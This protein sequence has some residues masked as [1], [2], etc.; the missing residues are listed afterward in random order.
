MSR[1]ESRFAQGE[2]AHLTLDLLRVKPGVKRSYEN[3]NFLK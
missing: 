2:E 3:W 1:N